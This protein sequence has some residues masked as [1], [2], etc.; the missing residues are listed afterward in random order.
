MITDRKEIANRLNLLL[1]RN[2]DAEQGYIEA[3]NNSSEDEIVKWLVDNSKLRN[4]FGHE[5]K[6][7]IIRM[8]EEPDKGTSVLGEL[9]QAYMD[10]KGYFTAEDPTAML[11]E[12]Q[13][14]EE[15]TLED[16]QEVLKEV[17]L[18]ADTEQ[19][20]MEQAVA[21]KANLKAIKTLISSYEHAES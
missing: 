12:C 15:K 13:F 11:N 6:A 10:L 7:H 4:K 21:V 18:P 20:I 16:Y 8:G 19:L 5:L 14:G 17:K 2:Y 9:H 3:A 1:T